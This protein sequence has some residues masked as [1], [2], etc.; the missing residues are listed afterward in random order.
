MFQ[1]SRKGDIHKCG[2][3]RKIVAIE[4]SQTK[5]VALQHETD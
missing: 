4:A 2:A 1:S 3:A 5:T